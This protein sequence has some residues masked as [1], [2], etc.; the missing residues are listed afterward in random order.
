MGNRSIEVENIRDYIRRGYPEGVD[1]LLKSLPVLF[2]RIEELEKALIP[3]ARAGLLD[4]DGKPLIYVHHSSC[5]NAFD[6]LSS[7]RA[8]GPKT[9]PEMEYLP[10]E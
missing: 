5:K 6:I 2:G 10:A 9:T 3:F 8:E 4:N 7:D 1:P